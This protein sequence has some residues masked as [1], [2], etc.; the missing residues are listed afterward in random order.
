MATKSKAPANQRPRTQQGDRQRDNSGRDNNGRGKSQGGAQRAARQQNG[1]QN[2]RPQQA[3]GA[4]NVGQ[5]PK[6]ELP[7]EIIVGDYITVR[8]LAVL[9]ERSPIDLI[10]ILMQ[11]GIMAPITHNL[12]HDT[13]VI[14][15]EELHV[16]VH[17][18][19]KD[20]TE[21]EED[22][23]AEPE[24]LSRTKRS[25]IERVVHEGGD[26]ALQ[27]RP[28]VVAVLGH[29]D[30]GK[31][32]LLDRIRHTDVA[33]GEAGG[34]TQRTGA[35][36]VTLNGRKITF[37][38]TPGH[39]AFTSMRARGAQVTDIVVLVVAAD[40][41]V[42]PQ[43][44]EAI[45]H[46]QAAGVT[47]VVALNKI[48]KPNANPQ[49]VMEELS[50]QG[51]QPEEWGGETMVVP[52]SALNGTGIDDL[53]EHILLVAE[54]E[55][56]KANAKGK[57][58]GTVV[59]SELD[60]FRGVTATLLV[61]NGTLSQGDAIVVGNTWGRIKAMFDDAGNI[62]KQA[63]PSTPVVVL[64]I[65]E[66][67]AAGEHFEVKK[68][69]REARRLAEERQLVASE[70]AKT[71]TRP[72]MSLDDLFLR[73]EGKETKTLNLIVRADMQGTLEPVVNSL[74]ELGND[75]VN[76][77]ILQATIGDI[78]ESDVMLAEASDAVI[79]GFSVSVDRAAQSRAEQSGVEIRKYDIIYKMIEDI[80]LAL[81]GMLEPIYEDITIGHAQVLQL[82]K[83]RRG[84]IAGCN[85]ID[86]IV[87]R[88]AL[89]RIV[90]N[91]KVLH[92]GMRLDTLR[93]FTEDVAEVR[94]GFECG[95]KL[96]SHDEGLEEGDII[97]IYEKQRTLTVR[98]R[99]SM[100]L[101]TLFSTACR[102]S[103]IGEQEMFL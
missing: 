53:L 82:F 1:Q 26:D 84:F 59:E 74:Q 66:V 80:D 77:K 97:E 47:I 32:T 44:K 60:K 28:P 43:T 12:D 87:K 62:I 56:Y 73:L 96:S 9:M 15:G 68:S 31:T 71:P 91:G 45:S 83:L 34:I 98:R 38:D 8:D 94:T 100:L 11:Y 49:R 41:G 30:H 88:N 63:G 33:A 14:L 4:G 24:P 25:L 5:V 102:K 3:R 67:P 79:I 39:E 69:D 10:K 58:V 85:V 93:R 90:R 76:I 70:A 42:M 52:L 27:S 48:D 101:N 89:T 19:A 35:Y 7:S 22:E 13:A 51:L 95:I 2:G 57:C 50:Q 40:D 81:T 99:G 78:S 20:Q 72:Q 16:K 23:E 61:Q 55:E 103:M 17:W 92:E 21:E 37:L 46:A 75:E 65:Q 18:P 36:Q 64:G 54:I 6:K 29:V 86:G